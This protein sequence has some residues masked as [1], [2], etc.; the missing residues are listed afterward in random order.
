MIGFLRT[1][2]PLLLMAMI[3]GLF[4]YSKLKIYE[5]QLDSRFYKAFNIIKKVIEPILELI[6]RVVKPYRVGPNISLDLSQ[7]ILL[8]ALLLVLKR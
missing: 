1:I 4:I 2:V 3:V 8:L 6:R 7:L 5:S